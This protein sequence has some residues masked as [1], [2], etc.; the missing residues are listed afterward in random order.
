MTVEATETSHELAKS[1]ARN[2]W[3]AALLAL[4]CLP[5]GY[6]YVGA[7]R[8]GMVWWLVGPAAQ[9]VGV[10]S[11]LAFPASLGIAVMMTIVLVFGALLYVVL[12][13]EVF[14]RARREGTGYRPRSYNRWYAYV[15]VILGV[16]VTSGVFG[17]ALRTQLQAFRN[18][19]Q[20]MAP[21]LLLGDYFFVDKTAGRRQS[22]AR[23]DLVVFPY[24][25][26][27][28]KEFVKR[29]V[30]L[31]N[32][33]IEIRGK[34]LLVNG[35]PLSEPYVIHSDSVIRPAES[36]LRDNMGPVRLGPRDFF[37]LGDNRDNSND[38]RY[39]GP[40]TRTDIKGI[41]KVIYWSWDQDDAVRWN[42]IGR[43]V[44]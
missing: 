37:V 40:V 2:P 41:A 3:L 10:F 31:P 26:D 11:V 17:A 16:M 33:T 39:W 21:T 12:P 22:L 20:S 32:E 30:G 35:A 34:Q 6:F 9:V 43:E 4:L 18:P 23:G 44:R 19:S 27:R 14:R 28:T 1:T 24:P 5:L 13:I 38:S 15:G 25:Q 8:R 29:I 42:R 36:D 7:A